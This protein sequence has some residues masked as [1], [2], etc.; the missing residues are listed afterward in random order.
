[1]RINMKFFHCGDCLWWYYRHSSLYNKVFHGYH[2]LPTT[3]NPPD[4]IEIQP[5]NTRTTNCRSPDIF[6]SEWLLWKIIL[7]FE[8]CGI[9]WMLAS[10]SECNP[11]DA[12][13]YTTDFHETVEIEYCPFAAT[14]HT[15]LAVNV[16]AFTA[17]NSIILQSQKNSIAIA[18]AL[19]HFFSLLPPGHVC[20]WCH[21]FWIVSA[22]PKPILW[23]PSIRAFQWN[24]ISRMWEWHETGGYKQLYLMPTFETSMGHRS[25]AWEIVYWS[26][27]GFPLV[28]H[29]QFT[30]QQQNHKTTSRTTIMLFSFTHR[31]HSPSANDGDTRR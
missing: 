7:R 17:M 11:D 13:A 16:T 6:W 26:W 27:N 18:R 2:Q 25:D 19:L 23:V 14:R 12:I 8:K 15:I 29:Q 31:S 1:M 28:C 3:S 24:N 5:S 30:Y 22:L 20:F 10:I 4:L 9:C 21:Y